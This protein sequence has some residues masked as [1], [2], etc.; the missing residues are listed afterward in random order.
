[1][2]QKRE[3]GVLDSV[4]PL[5][6]SVKIIT[7]VVGIVIGRGECGKVLHFHQ[8]CHALLDFPLII[9]DS[10]KVRTVGEDG[11]NHDGEFIVCLFIVY[12]WQEL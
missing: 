6:I 7:K 3:L 8:L 11:Y 5:G 10:V 12:S 9:S 1:M 2:R 4:V